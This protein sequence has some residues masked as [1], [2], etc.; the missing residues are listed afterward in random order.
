MAETGLPDDLMREFHAL[1]EWAGT[2]PATFGS[3]VEVRL[4][5]A[6]S[7]EGFFK[8]LVRRFRRFPAFTVGDRRYVGSDFRQVNELIAE[9]LQLGKVQAAPTRKGRDT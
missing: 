1:S 3:R 6:A 7:V 8:S 5:D 2:L 9:R 4:V